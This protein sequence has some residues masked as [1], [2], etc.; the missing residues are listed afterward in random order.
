MKITYYKYIYKYYKYYKYLQ[1]LI[2]NYKPKNKVS[3]R[4][5]SLKTGCDFVHKKIST[6]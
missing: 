3:F 1:Y 6:L 5:K 2:Q 4:Q